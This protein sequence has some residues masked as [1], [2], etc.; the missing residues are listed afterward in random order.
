MYSRGDIDGGYGA[1]YAPPSGPGFIP[2]ESESADGI[3]SL[4]QWT[5]ELRIASNDAEVFNWLVGA[6]Y[7]NEDVDIDSFSYASLR[8]PATPRT[9]TRSRPSRPPATPSSDRSTSRSRRTGA[10]NWA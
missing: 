1:V 7:F 5:E 9:G 6:Y 3:P 8:A 2:F 10:S 4:T